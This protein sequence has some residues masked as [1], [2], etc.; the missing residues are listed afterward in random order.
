METTDSKNI[1]NQSEK[2][3]S[4]KECADVVG[5]GQDPAACRHQ[6]GDGLH[7]ILY[8]VFVNASSNGIQEKR[9]T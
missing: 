8:R 3:E 9:R 5:T 6:N 7:N 4:E 2:K 1:Y